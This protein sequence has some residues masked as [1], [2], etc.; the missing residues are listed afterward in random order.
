MVRQVIAVLII[1]RWGIVES[2]VLW[3]AVY[4][5]NT[6]APFV[7]IGH[8]KRD[9]TGSQTGEMDIVSKKNAWYASES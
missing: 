6:C 9:V 5:N 3:F 4:A 8:K 7:G 2:N 1:Q